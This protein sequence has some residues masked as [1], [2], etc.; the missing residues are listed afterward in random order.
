MTRQKDRM[1]SVQRELSVGKGGGLEFQPVPLEPLYVPFDP[2]S[3]TPR[4][5]GQF[6]ARIDH[7]A[8]GS[9][10]ALSVRPSEEDEYSLPRS[11]QFL[12]SL[13]ARY[14][15]GFEVAGADGEVEIQL[16]AAPPDV[17]PILGQIKAH[18][19]G[20]EAFESEDCLTSLTTGLLYARGYRL[21]RSHLFPLREGHRTDPYTALLGLLGSLGPD[22]SA[23][24]QVLFLPARSDWKH[25]IMTVARDPFD[26][27]K[28]AFPDVPLLK[29]AEAKA[30][31]PLFAVGIR[32][33][34]SSAGLLD[35]L[36]GSFFSQF[37]SED[38]SLVPLAEPYPIGDILN[39]SNYTSGI[40]LNAG[41]LAGLVHIPDP[42]AMLETLTVAEP[43][44]PAPELARQNILAPLGGNH[45]Q[46]KD[47]LTGIPA[48]QLSRH[49][50]I[51]GG[52]GYGKTNLMKFCFAPLLERGYG[53]AVIDP[54]GDLAKGLLDLVPEHR[55]K[56]VVWF[57]PTDRA[58]PPA[59]NVLQSS[60]QLEH[61]TLT[62]ELMVGL[63]R[64][65][66]GNSE[67]GPRME[68]ILRNA[69]RTLLASQGEKTLH[70]VP[71]FL[72]DSTFRSE[73]LA[74]VGDRELREFWRN[75]SLSH[76]VIDPVLN[77]LSSFLDRPSIR[78]VVSQPNKIDFHQIMREGK[79]FI[80][81]LEKGLLQDA[82][83][84]LGSFI[85]S[86]LQLAALARRE[87]ERK[88]F[89]ILVDEFHNFAATG[90]DTQSI[91]TFLSEARSYMAPLVVSTQYVGRLNRDVIAA[92]FGNVGTMICM[93]LGQLDA[94]PMQREFGD[95]TAEDMMDLEIG[96]AVVRMGPARDAFKIRTPL[97]LPRKSH[98][99]T[100]ISL[101]REMYWPPRSKVESMLGRTV[102]ST[103]GAE[104]SVVGAGGQ[105]E[106]ESKIKVPVTNADQW[107]MLE[108][109]ADHPEA[110]VTAVSSALGFSAWRG[111]NARKYLRD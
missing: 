70:D 83:F 6:R 17:D 49:V 50:A 10:Q 73:V 64:L 82:S 104:A 28:S 18:Y 108:Y 35:R 101:S 111:S 69:V 105:V 8:S 16:V 60:G 91:E 11:E 40:L 88:L 2:F 19:A 38:N 25:N 98:R 34:A 76:T 23:L 43:G 48:Q 71:R 33:A 79:I 96:E 84:V 100:I 13:D 27:S 45:H 68:W 42:S 37:Q 63:K 36:Q 94:Q 95:F 22:E 51:F 52:T 75:R 65:F 72:E 59:L 86:R 20:C 81:N 110:T 26:P 85:L 61:E 39:R 107:R 62:S 106:T 4:S 46:G 56:D 7:H 92:M 15:V 66:H 44:S 47:T 14:P 89:P 90:M 78:D 21:R 93:H 12:L 80:A 3:T 87:G 30:A 99:K 55:I 57:D 77:R 97:V 103:P 9:L 58:F 67:F 102:G 109:A 32:L 1:A 41:E 74:T 54:K 53:M 31:K 29:R 24:Y 5:G